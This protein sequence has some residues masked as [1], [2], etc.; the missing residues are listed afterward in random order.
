VEFVDNQYCLFNDRANRE[1]QLKMWKRFNP[2]KNEEEFEFQ[3]K[4]DFE[5]EEIERAIEG[6]ED[7]CP[8]EESITELINFHVL[9][10]TFSNKLDTLSYLNRIKNNCS[11]ETLELARKT[12]GLYH[13]KDVHLIQKLNM[14]SSCIGT[15]NGK[16]FSK[17]EEEFF[18]H[19]NPFWNRDKTRLHV[20]SNPYLTEGILIELDQEKVCNWIE[21]IFQMKINLSPSSFLSNLKEQDR[22]YCEVKKLLHTLS[23]LFLKKSEIYTGIDVQS[24]GEMLFPKTASFLIYP[25]STTNIG[26]FSSLFESDIERLIE[27]TDF[28]I[29]NCIYDPICLDNEGACF[30]CLYLPEHVCCNFNQELDRDIL[31]GRTKRYPRSFFE[32]E[33]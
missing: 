8:I 27:G 19:F 2:D 14:I 30:S 1:A 21:E 28:D 18:P 26:G 31:L 24:C 16:T 3:R 11:E 32:N 23:H 9:K 10:G 29:K 17:E 22:E 15:I 12:L 25:T 7:L 13:I 6:V 33:R 4:K 5:I 20:Y